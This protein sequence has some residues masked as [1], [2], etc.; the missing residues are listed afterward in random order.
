MLIAIIVCSIQQAFAIGR[1]CRTGVVALGIVCAAGPVGV[2]RAHES[3]SGV[4]WLD[5]VRTID[6]P[7]YYADHH[8]TCFF[9][10]YYPDSALHE[11][12]GK[13]SNETQADRR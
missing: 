6:E 10:G 5:A 11:G 4:P 13:G 8:G 9:P 12:G 7:G 2:G 3:E 1:P